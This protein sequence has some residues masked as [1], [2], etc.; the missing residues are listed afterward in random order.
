MGGIGKR[1]AKRG[2]GRG[3]GRDEGGRKRRGKG[4]GRG[5]GSKEREE[6]G[7]QLKEKRAL[8][9]ACG[10]GD[11]ARE[12]AREGVRTRIGTVPF[13]WYDPPPQSRH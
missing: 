12:E 1:S 3:E 9:G 10:R 4:G 8:I 5:V 2:S 11:E 13:A 7:R 6:G